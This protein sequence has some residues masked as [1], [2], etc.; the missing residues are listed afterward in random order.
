MMKV[1]RL[2]AESSGQGTLYA[3]NSFRSDANLHNG[4]GVGVRLNKDA[5]ER[6]IKH[7]MA[8]ND[9]DNEDGTPSSKKS[10][11]K[12]KKSKHEKGEGKHDKSASKPKSLKR[13]KSKKAK[14]T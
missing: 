1:K 8:G 6:F 7:A 3:F 9:G 2:E 14:D 11:S 13:K 5:A 10:K 12:V 4:L